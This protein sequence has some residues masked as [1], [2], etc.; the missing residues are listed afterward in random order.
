MANVVTSWRLAL[1]TALDTAFPDA[2]VKSG[3]RTG[4]SRDKDRIN[5]FSDP[6]VQ[7]HLPERIVVSSPRMV[8]R[9]WKKRSEMP[10]PDSPPDPTELEQARQDLETFIQSHQKPSVTDL[11]Y[12]QL[13]SLRVDEDPEEWGVEARLV[14]YG[15]NLALLA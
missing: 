4:V 5:V 7:G 3:L 6:Q 11:W 12:C 9:Y 10:P 8:I 2:E 13:E 15:R 1:V 14:G